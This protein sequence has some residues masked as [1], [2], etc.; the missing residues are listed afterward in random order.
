[1]SRVHPLQ[2]PRALCAAWKRAESAYLA[3][4]DV[5]VDAV[6]GILLDLTDGRLRPL[7]AVTHAAGRAVSRLER[8]ARMRR[9]SRAGRLP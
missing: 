1:M 8:A 5:A 2:A 6:V 4:E 7:D 9:G 3:A